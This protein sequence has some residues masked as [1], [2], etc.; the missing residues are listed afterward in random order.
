MN[1]CA[2]GPSAAVFMKFP[3]ICFLM[4]ERVKVVVCP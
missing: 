2:L 4:R 1:D 3:L